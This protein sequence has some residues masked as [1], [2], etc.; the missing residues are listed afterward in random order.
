M[1]QE[2]VKNWMTRHVITVTPDTTLPEARHLLTYHQ[3]R[4]LPVT[5]NDKP[6]GIITLG[7]IRAAEPS[8]A[9]SLKKWELN[10]LVP[11]IK[12]KQIMTR[13]PITV[14]PHTI[15]GEVAWLFQALK[16][17]GLPVVDS[18]GRVVGII[19]ESDIFRM[20]IEEWSQAVATTSYTNGKSKSDIAEPDYLEYKG[21]RV[22]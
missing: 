7:D 22:I 5:K 13:N 11:R 16:I 1:K 8:P 2:I 18:K 14:T 17:S 19:T 6:V 21:E 12:V 20:V 3:L 9:T 15:I 10:Y 4:H